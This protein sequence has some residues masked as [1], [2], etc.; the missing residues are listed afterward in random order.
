MQLHSDT[1]LDDLRMANIATLYRQYAPPLLAYLFQHLPTGEDA[2]DIL[3]EVFLAAL[4]SE[5]F[6][7][8][9]EK[10]QLAWLWRVARNKM[11]DAYRRLARRSNVTLES[12]TEGFI[13]NDDIGPET[14]V[15]MQ[16]EYDNLMVH[17]KSLSPLQQ[18]VLRL[19]FSLDMRCSEIAAHLG[20][21]EGA[22]KVMMSRALNLLKKIYKV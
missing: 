1:T 6:P 12:I 22:V 13:D 7:S 2:E 5:L 20:K 17:L 21:H 3:V 15:L 11:V 16:E 19:H 4:E 9:S 18:E 10:A 8:L 14:F